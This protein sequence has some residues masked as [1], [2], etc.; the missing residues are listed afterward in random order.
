MR[1]RSW[2]GRSPA[3]RDPSAADKQVFTCCGS[4]SATASGATV[5]PA[6]VSPRDDER[7]S[8]LL[9]PSHCDTT[10]LSHPMPPCCFLSRRFSRRSRE[11]DFSPDVGP[12]CGPSLRWRHQGAELPRHRVL[13]HDVPHMD[14][15]PCRLAPASWTPATFSR[16]RAC[17]QHGTGIVWILR[18][19]PRH[20][21]GPWAEAAKAGWPGSGSCGA[22]TRRRRFRVP[23]VPALGG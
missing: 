6:T 3:V 10:V 20:P 1:S 2:T 16:G 15:V 21:D 14:E 22:P 18:P 5:K 17:R 13:R 12:S 23:P 7:N 4:H 19:R 9:T 8:S 11:S